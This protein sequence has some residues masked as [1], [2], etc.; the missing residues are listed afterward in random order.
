MSETP[1]HPVEPKPEQAPPVIP[2]PPGGGPVRSSFSLWGFV[3]MAVLIAVLIWYL[4]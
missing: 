3:L 2:E 4:M 1:D